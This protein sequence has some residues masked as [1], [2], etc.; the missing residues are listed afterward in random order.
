MKCP[1]C[2][3]GTMKNGKSTLTVERKNA[4]IFFKQVPA[5]VCNNCGETFFSSDVSK[6]VYKIAEEAFNKGTELEVIKMKK[7][8]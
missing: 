2:K 7:I 1:I 6:Q 8:A 4:L 3:E 5:L